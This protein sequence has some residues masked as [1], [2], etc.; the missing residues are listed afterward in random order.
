[1][2]LD[3]KAIRTEDL[4][5]FVWFD[6][7]TADPAGARDFYSSLLGWEAD[8]NGM[9]AGENGPWAA[10]AEGTSGWVP[11]VQVDDV[12]RATAR[13][14]E[15]GATVIG[16]RREGPAGIFTTITDPTGAALS[17]WQPAAS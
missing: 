13:A 4:M 9:L 14:R 15:L 1:M 6:L 11:Y 2:R 3:G 17:L 8:G 5:G 10:I 12:D 7:R 16:D